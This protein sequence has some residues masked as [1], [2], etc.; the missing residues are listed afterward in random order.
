MF[1]R[2]RGS[3]SGNIIL[4][5][6][7]YTSLIYYLFSYYQAYQIQAA[8]WLWAIV[9]WKINIQR[10]T[11]SPGHLIWCYYISCVNKMR[12]KFGFYP[13]WAIHLSSRKNQRLFNVKNIRKTYTIWI[14]IVYVFSYK[15]TNYYYY[16]E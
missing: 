14:W 1:L 3:L 8:V 15:D 5:I 7:K 4:Y 2:K 12:G 6:R 9:L 16:Y 10:I 13:P 11:G